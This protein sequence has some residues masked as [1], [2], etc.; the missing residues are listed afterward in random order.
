MSNIHFSEIGAVAPIGP[1]NLKNKSKQQLNYND[2]MIVSKYLNTIQ[3]YINLTKT[4][5]NYKNI[6]DNFLYRKAK[7]DLV[8]YMLQSDFRYKDI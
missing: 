4:C 1:S 8:A 6:P 7:L 5:K 3:D 2:V